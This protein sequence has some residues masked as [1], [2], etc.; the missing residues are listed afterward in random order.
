MDLH[1]AVDS[2]R[3]YV[4]HGRPTGGFLRAV[5]ANDLMEAIRRGDESSLENLPAICR[6]IYNDIP[7]NVHGSYERVDQH[8]AV[9]QA[10]RHDDLMGRVG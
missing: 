10:Q 6:Y 5:L 4:D 2:I 8:I 3:W 9:K 7:A 1:E